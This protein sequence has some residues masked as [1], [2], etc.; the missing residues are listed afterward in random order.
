MAGSCYRALP[1]TEHVRG[2]STVYDDLQQ[3]PIQFS[4]HRILSNLYSAQGQPRTA[5]TL[6]CTRPGG[7]TVDIINVHA[8][9]GKQKLTDVQRTTLLRN[10]L[11]SN[12]LSIPGAANGGARFSIGG[13]MNTGSFRMSKLLQDHRELMAP[14]TEQQ[15][16]DPTF[17][18]H[19]DLCMSGVSPSG[20]LDSHSRQSRSHAQ[21]LRNMLV[22]A[23]GVCYGAALGGS[24]KTS[25]TQRASHASTS[26]LA[27]AGSS[28][29]FWVCYR[30]ALASTSKSSSNPGAE[31]ASRTSLGTLATRVCSRAT[32]AS[33]CKTSSNPR[34]S[35][36]RE[37]S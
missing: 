20:D 23:A 8:P 10:L 9:S 19:G 34:A 22:H 5:Q 26:R 31:N 24:S 33:T 17:P 36:A 12:S 2:R 7:V 15:L 32:L 35:K 37:R 4:G 16:H 28:F 18:Q 1:P 21:A 11:Q 27:L 30:A 6:L 14:R 3:G 29:I 13:D 25:S